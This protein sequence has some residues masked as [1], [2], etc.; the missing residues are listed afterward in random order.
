MKLGNLKPENLKSKNIY[1]SLSHQL[2]KSPD[3]TSALEDDVESFIVA[4]HV[5]ITNES[6]PCPF[7]MIKIEINKMKPGDF[8][9]KK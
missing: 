2:P 5:P 9:I 7:K 6:I 4:A 1:R 8:E 3:T